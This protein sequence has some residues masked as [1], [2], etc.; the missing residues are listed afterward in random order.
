MLNDITFGQFYPAKSLVHKMDP[1]F[2]MVLTVAFIVFTFVAQNAIS[3]VITAAALAIFIA[4]TRIP[5]KMYLK[6]LKPIIPIIILTSVLNALYVSGGDTVVSFWKITITTGGITTAVY[7]SVRTAILIMCSSILTYTT[8]PTEL[9]DAIERLFSPLNAIKVDVHS[10]AMM[11]TI[12]LR[13]IPTLIEETD[14]I[15]SAQKA[16]GA[17]IESGGLI[18][19]VK[20]LVPIL[21]PLLISSFR[22]ASEL[23]DAMECRC[24][25]GGEGRTRMKVM[26]ASAI[27]YV[28]TGVFALLL[29]AIILSNTY[30]GGIIY[31]L[32][33]G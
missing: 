3:L 23:A 19:R 12:A 32:I 17:D 6:T 10:L 4:A 7:M 33:K 28:S 22:R 2:K 11:M 30:C 26:K 27:D 31:S 20:A 15:M 21:I 29:A 24:Y 5:V 13:F 8:S 25:H 14:K 1:R 16:R 18:K 9:T